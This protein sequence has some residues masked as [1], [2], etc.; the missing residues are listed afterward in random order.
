MTAEQIQDLVALQT[1]VTGIVTILDGETKILTEI[2]TVSGVSDANITA[3]NTTM[4]NA[5]TAID[6]ILSP[7]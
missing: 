4:T 6:T 7:P 3:L 2:R 5:L 1:L